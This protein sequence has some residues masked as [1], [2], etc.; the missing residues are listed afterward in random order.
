[1]TK[2]LPK[3][4]MSNFKITNTV[5]QKTNLKTSKIAKKPIKIKELIGVH[6]RAGRSHATEKTE[7]KIGDFW[8]FLRFSRYTCVARLKLPKVHEYRGLEAHS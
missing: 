6:L 2:I 8:V 7:S 1:M 4:E 3:S 5:F